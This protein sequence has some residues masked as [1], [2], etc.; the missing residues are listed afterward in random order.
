M[1]IHY[2]MQLDNIPDS[3]TVTVTGGDGYIIELFEIEFGL[4]CE[5]TLNVLVPQQGFITLTFDF[6]CTLPTTL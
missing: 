3:G 2:F 1:T 5:G 6:P 4:V